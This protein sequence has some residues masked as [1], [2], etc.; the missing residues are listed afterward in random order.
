MVARA[1]EPLDA[2]GEAC[3]YVGRGGMPEGA[4]ILKRDQ[5][6]TFA[7]GYLMP[8]VG[9]V[10]RFD[11]LALA[12]NATWRDL[13]VRVRDVL[14]SAYQFPNE[15]SVRREHFELPKRQFSSGGSRSA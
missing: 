2:R 5:A 4:F 14:A 7:T 15:W 12:V 10:Y 11:R 1:A 3:C 9:D 8:A 13:L 6:G